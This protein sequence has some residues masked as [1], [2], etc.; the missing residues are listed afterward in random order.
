MERDLNCEV[1][2]MENKWRF[3]ASGHGNRKGISPGDTETFKKSPFE[4]FAREILQNSIDARDSDEE[5]TRVEFKL[6]EMPTDS[7]PGYQELKE[8]IRRCLE[9][10][11]FKKDYIEA[12]SKLAALLEDES[13]TCLRV[14]DFNTTGLIG[15]NTENQI[16][17][18]YLALIKGTGVS[19]KGS[20]LA[21]GSKGLGKNAVF[22][23]SG[24][25]TAFYSTRANKD[26]DGNPGNYSGSIGV[27]DLISGYI[28]DFGGSNRDYTQGKG[29]FSSNNLNEPIDGTLSLDESFQRG[30][31]EFGTDI[32]IIGFNTVE[33]WETEI[34][35]SVLDSFLPAIVR[36]HL[37]V[38]VNNTYI[39]REN[40]KEI[41]YD[42]SI[43]YKN[44][45]SNII[46]LY[47]L[48]TCDGE[49]R[50]YDID[51]EYGSCSL[52]ILPLSKDEESLATHKCTMI[53]YPLMKIKNEPLG[54][55]FRVS[56]MCVIEDNP[57]GQA[58]RNI[59]NAQHTDWE[60]KRISDKSVRREIDNLLRSIKEQIKEKVIE[61]LQLGDEQP[62]DPNGAGDYLP[63]VGVGDSPNE[64]NGNQK[65]LE[66]VTVSK[67]K[68]NL[69][70]EKNARSYSEDGNS[71]QPD[72][73][74]IDESMEGD[75][76]YP[77]GSNDVSGGENHPGSLSGGSIE[78]DNVVFKRKKLAGVRYKVISTNK[79]KGELRV[80][81]V[82]PCDFKTCYL[83]L[84]MLDDS[85]KALNV[86]ILEMKKNGID[87]ESQ[88]KNEY[89]PFEIST[90][91]RVVLDVKTNAL[92]FFASE[93]K[94]VCK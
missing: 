69:T 60:T 46:S 37:E 93:V 74:G 80:I 6:F 48:L 84:V 27:A 7:I 56:A 91:E 40:V 32:F 58:L 83:N 78:G 94:V 30:E 73:G 82:S 5:P 31:N 86:E 51:T 20:G 25:S 53:R 52:Y 64:S 4:S 66:T 21:A 50:T 59:E 29:Y 2:E 57:L 71:L 9:F 62:L 23:M 19:E 61:C 14:S 42:D 22:L 24:I 1:L 38:V 87:I 65:P 34:I 36:G 45:R 3:P 12:Y 75:V 47:R 67:P 68:E 33:D 92:G 26:I 35:N 13:I 39:D 8:Q 55:S 90:N 15:V 77:D 88:D 54:A 79:A 28:D 63:D 44:N 76:S 81:F 16:N 49:V 43:V 85:N 89:G 17:N 72:I 70:I 11:D 18:K 41:V 10:W